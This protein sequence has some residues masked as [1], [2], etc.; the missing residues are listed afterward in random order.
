MYLVFLPAFGLPARHLVSS[1]YA[2]FPRQTR[3]FPARHLASPPDT[4][5]PCQTL[6]FTARFPRQTLGF[7]A[8]H[9]VSRQTC[10]VIAWTE[11]KLEFTWFCSRVI[12]N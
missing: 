4:W 2:W 5:L 6:G 1:S 10:A 7:S 9:V 12:T 11:A 3:G 8:R